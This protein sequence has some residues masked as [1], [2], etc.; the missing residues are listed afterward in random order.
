MYVDQTTLLTVLETMSTIQKITFLTKFVVVLER[1]TL[2]TQLSGDLAIIIDDLILICHLYYKYN[3]Q[4]NSHRG[5]GMGSNR[6]PN[7]PQECTIRCDFEKIIDFYD[8]CKK[9]CKFSI[10]WGDKACSSFKRRCY[11]KRFPERPDLLRTY[12]ILGYYK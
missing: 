7:R 1:Y 10:T 12:K 9:Y 3:L 2:L 6:A 4:T 11:S 8:K 5:E